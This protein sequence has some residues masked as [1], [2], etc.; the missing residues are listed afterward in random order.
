MPNEY[1]LTPLGMLSVKKVPQICLLGLQI[2]PYFSRS[3]G[4]MEQKWRP[5]FMKKQVHI[6]NF[7]IW[8]LPRKNFK[9]KLTFCLPVCIR[10]AHPDLSHFD[11]PCFR[12]LALFCFRE[13]S[14]QDK[15]HKF[16]ES[17]WSSPADKYT[18]QKIKRYL[19]HPIISIATCYI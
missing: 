3:R 5:M 8:H 2:G 12:I 11:K 17:F 4:H 19:I 13:D 10:T 7:A 1:H 16:S 15:T 14:S 6:Q 9:P 18:Y